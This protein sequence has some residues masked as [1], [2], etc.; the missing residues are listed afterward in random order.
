VRLGQRPLARDSREGVEGLGALAMRRKAA[1]TPATALTFPVA[2][3][4][5]LSA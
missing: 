4:C 3:A 1:A 5:A 2:T